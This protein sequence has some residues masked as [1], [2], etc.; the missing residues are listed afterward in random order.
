MTPTPHTIGPTRS[1]AAARKLMVDSHVRHLPVLD[2]ARIVG[3]L[4]E[5]DLFLVESL[6]GVNPTVVRVEEAMVQNV[7]TVGPDTPVGVVVATMI[8][9]KLGSTVVC[10]G[11]HVVGVF[12]TI[13]ALQALLELLEKPQGR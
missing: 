7:F 13:D 1:L 11:Q 6:P 5:R 9:R 4:S 2:E 8:E 3:L 10:E 12:T